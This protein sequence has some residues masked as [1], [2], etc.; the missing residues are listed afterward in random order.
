MSEKNKM[1][2]IAKE[3]LK[4]RVKALTPEEIDVVLDNIPIQKIAMHL[5]GQLAMM[6]YKLM[7]VQEV[8]A[9]GWEDGK[10][11]GGKR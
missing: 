2:E 1:S 4:D 3:E 11:V 9:D 10:V 7:K 6:Q 8:S 5:G